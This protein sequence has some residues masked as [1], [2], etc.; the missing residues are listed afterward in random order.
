M[1]QAAKLFLKYNVAG[2][3]KRKRMLWIIKQLYTLILNTFCVLFCDKKVA[4]WSSH[5][6]TPQ[7]HRATQLC[8]FSCLEITY[9][10]L[11]RTLTRMWV[12]TCNST[13]LRKEENFPHK[14]W[15]WVASYTQSDECLHTMI[16]IFRNYYT[17]EQCRECIEKNVGLCLW[18]P[19]TQ[20]PDSG[21]IKAVVKHSK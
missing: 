14:G 16:C 5:I 17:L 18:L 4:S 19:L 7:N 21:Y 20:K 2:F 11:K 6:T 10:S 13:V 3:L 9:D 8:D 15:E 1:P 12:S